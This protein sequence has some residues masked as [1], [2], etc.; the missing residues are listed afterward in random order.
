MSAFELQALGLELRW[1]DFGFGIK[2]DFAAW[3]V[4]LQL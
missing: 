1:Q 4:Q 3:G 2:L